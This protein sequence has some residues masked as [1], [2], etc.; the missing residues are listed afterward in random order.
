[1]SKDKKLHFQIM[2]NANDSSDWITLVHGA[3]HDSRYFSEQ[4]S[5]FQ[6]QYNLLLIDIRGHGKSTAVPGPYGFE[7]Y[8]DDVLEAVDETQIKNIHF[9]GSHTGATI[10]LIIALR[11][12]HLIKSLVLEGGFANDYPM[13]RVNEIWN[14][15]VST[16]LTHGVDKA[17]SDWF[18]H[19]DWFEYIH[20][21]MDSTQIETH[22]KLVCTFKGQPWTSTLEPRPD[23]P[24]SEKLKTI[25]QPALLLNGELDSE[26]FKGAA[27]DLDNRLS[28]SHYV[29]VPDA[30]GYPSWENYKI[31]NEVV[32]N[33][34]S[35]MSH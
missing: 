30:G 7:E 24:F 29:E 28:N 11:R 26:E 27:T 18:E 21:H 17:V 13:P 5:T 31:T 6:Y 35:K 3:A 14:Q 12:P 34:L 19:A 2:Q 4:V 23:I 20:N 9:W 16:S 22:R 10:G 25:T 33:F 8:A 15:A 32:N 1:M